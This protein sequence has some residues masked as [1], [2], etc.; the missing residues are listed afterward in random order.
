VIDEF[1]ALHSTPDLEQDKLTDIEWHT[2]R[3]IKD[4]LEKLSM[5]T[6][7]CESAELTL[8]LTFP[9]STISSNSL[10]R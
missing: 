7:A 10:N 6:K 4:F 2:V 9:S 8:N 5:S 3:V 1:I